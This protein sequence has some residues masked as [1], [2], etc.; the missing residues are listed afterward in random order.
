MK[1][2]QMRILLLITALFMVFALTGQNI[3]LNYAISKNDVNKVREMVERG[4][5]IHRLDRFGNT[6]LTLAVYNGNMEIVQLLVEHGAELDQQDQ[7]GNTPLIV[8][9]LQG[10]IDILNYLVQQGAYIDEPGPE[11]R[12]PL[13]YAILGTKQDKKQLIVEELINNGADVNL[14]DKYKRTALD[15]CK[16]EELKQLLI[17]YGGEHGKD[18][19]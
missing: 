11:E 10:H 1:I 2:Y 6:S 9:S 16:E 13:M 14:T 4:H 7:R 15:Y 18:L 8:A 17:Q 3:T 19:E 12:T 5:D